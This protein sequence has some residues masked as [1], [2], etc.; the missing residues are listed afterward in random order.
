MHRSFHHRHIIALCSYPL[1]KYAADEIVDVVRNHE[2]A[3]SRRRGHWELISNATLLLATATSS[4][5][6]SALR[7]SDEEDASEERTRRRLAEEQ[8]RLYAAEREARA[9]TESV[10]R[11]LAILQ[12]IA[13]ALS[14]AL[15]PDEVGRI[16]ARSMAAA[17][18]AE[19][20]FLAVPSSEPDRLRVLG[21]GGDGASS[22]ARAGSAELPL[23]APLPLVAAFSGVSL[24]FTARAQIEKE[25]PQCC[26]PC[27]QALACVPTRVADRVVGVIRIGFTKE[28]TFTAEQRAL[29]EDLAR[30]VG[31]ALERSFLHEQADQ[32]RQR[33]EE[34]NRAK[35][36]F[37]AMLGHELRNPLSPHRHRTGADAAERDG[38]AR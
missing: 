36:E 33:A 8:L 20:T 1:F 23:S 7:S 11:H 27:T 15:T 31:L 37:M 17:L 16:V 25:F 12:D 26:A 2:R 5:T 19:Y 13:S 29:L 4:D 21:L 32:A 3:L 30:Q 14:G 28:Q 10:T 6:V 22:D 9:Q 34:A 35:D 38:S 18:G 24:W